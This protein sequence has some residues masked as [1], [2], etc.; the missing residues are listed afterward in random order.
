MARG[1][2]ILVFED[3]DKNDE[4]LYAELAEHAANAGV[5]FG[6]ADYDIVIEDDL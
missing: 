2:L 3:P 5:D 1:K 4:E 6:C